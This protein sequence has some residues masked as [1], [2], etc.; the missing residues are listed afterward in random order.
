[1]RGAH[2]QIALVYTLGDAY[3]LEYWEDV[4]K[5]IQDMG[6][7]SLCIKDMSGLLRPYSAYELVTALKKG[8]P[9]LPIDL[10]T[11][12]TSGQAA[13]TYMKAIEAGCDIIDCASAPFSMGTSQPATDVMVEALRGT[14]YEPKMDQKLVTKVSDYF[15]PYREECI[16]S[17]R[18]STKVLGVNI[19]T[20]LYQVP[21][22]ML[23]NMIKQLD[24]QGKGDKLVS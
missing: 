20:M 23:S 11:H 18:M 13:M 7:D 14:P 24:E 15:T 21:G 1:M 3:T 5:R 10:H 6:A 9:D 16:K 2:A 19:R 12:Y 4:A 8:A 17:G 22:G